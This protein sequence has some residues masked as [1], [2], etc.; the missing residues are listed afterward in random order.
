M[1]VAVVPGGERQVDSQN[2]RPC[3]MALTALCHSAAAVS[4]I[5]SFDLSS[6]FPSPR[7]I[8]GHSDRPRRSR[9]D[10][11]LP[12][13]RHYLHRCHYLSPATHLAALPAHRQLRPDPSLPLYHCHPRRHHHR[14]ISPNRRLS[15]N[16]FHQVIPIHL[17]RLLLVAQNCRPAGRGWAT[18]RS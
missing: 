12:L 11:S 16:S 3:P 15:S 14:T 10:P 7:G 6:S 5:S 18:A 9:P 8:S 4:S 1:S 2:H 17:F 13:H